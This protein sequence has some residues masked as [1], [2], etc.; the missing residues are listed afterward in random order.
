M[1]R[2]KSVNKLGG[3]LRKSVD[4]TTVRQRSRIKSDDYI[5]R[6]REVRIPLTVLCSVIFF[7]SLLVRTTS[8]NDG[9]K[10]K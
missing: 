6:V 7:T 3:G 8:N 1:Q 9:E 5:D 10:C 4:A 2:K